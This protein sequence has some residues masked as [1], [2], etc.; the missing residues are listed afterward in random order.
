M[1]SYYVLFELQSKII[2]GTYR[3]ANSKEEAIMNAEFALMCYYPN[4]KY[5]KCY[6]TAVKD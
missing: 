6:I 4:V 3:R 2:C 5:D 1:K